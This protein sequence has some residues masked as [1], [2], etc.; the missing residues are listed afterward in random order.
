[1][2]ITIS[3]PP[4]SG[5]TTVAKL[6]AEKMGYPLLSGGMIFREMAREMGMDLVEFSRYAELHTEVDSRIDRE[7]VDRARVMENVVIDSRLGGWMLHK[8]GI[9]AFKVYIDASPDVRAR[10]IMGRDGGS[11][12]IVK[13]E[14]LLREESERKRYLRLYG[15]DY[16]DLSIYDLVVD[17]DNM[18]PMDVLKKILEVIGWGK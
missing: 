3:G 14:M 1:M 18:S 17:T 16:E 7:I 6:L 9:P 10:R 4:G 8:H 11:F 12:E 15:I 2:R 13:R 5:K